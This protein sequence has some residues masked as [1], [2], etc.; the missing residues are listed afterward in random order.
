MHNFNMTL[1][2]MQ[3]C[4]EISFP[5]YEFTKLVIPKLSVLCVST[6]KWEFTI[7]QL[8]QVGAYWPL[9]V[10]SC[11]R[12]LN[13]VGACSPCMSLRWLRHVMLCCVMYRGWATEPSSPTLRSRGWFSYRTL[14]TSRSDSFTSLARKLCSA[15]SW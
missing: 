14:S 8:N 3:I 1:N 10:Y 9:Y 6:Y 5:N 13:C 11:T 7:Q 4:P 15:F 2:Y 12:W